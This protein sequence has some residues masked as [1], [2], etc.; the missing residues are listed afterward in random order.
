MLDQELPTSRNPNNVPQ[1]KGAVLLKAVGK[2]GELKV[3]KQDR[4]GMTR[5][6]GRSGE[7]S[8]IDLDPGS[9]N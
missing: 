1:R 6:G 9:F 3:E 5:R 2:K 7:R 4:L 8:Q